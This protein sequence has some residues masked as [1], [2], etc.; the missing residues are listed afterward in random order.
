MTLQVVVLP[1]GTVSGEQLT[2]VLVDASPTP[3][4]SD[5]WLAAWPPS[6]P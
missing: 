1:T 3:S 4:R 2:D 6:P 5:P